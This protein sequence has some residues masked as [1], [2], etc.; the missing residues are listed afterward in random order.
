MSLFRRGDVWWYEFWF[1]GRRIQESS[2]SISKTVA[3]L[4]ARARR[5]REKA[6]P[7]PSTPIYEKASTSTR[8][9]TGS[10]LQK[11]VQNGTSFRLA[12]HA[13]ATLPGL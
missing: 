5:T 10:V 9:G 3:K 2:K 8:S 13:R 1:A 7:S 4:S 6:A 11:P 12:A